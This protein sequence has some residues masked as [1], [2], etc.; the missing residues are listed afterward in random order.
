MVLG[1][2]LKE[3][4]QFSTMINEVKTFE[5]YRVL[6]VHFTSRKFD[7]LKSKTIHRIDYAKELENRNDRLL[8]KNLS[9]LCD[10]PKE[11]ASILVSNFAYGNMYPLENLEKTNENYKTWLKVKNSLGYTFQSDLL[12]LDKNYLDD[13]FEKFLRKKIS[14][15]TICLINH[16]E[17]FTITNN[18]SPIWDGEGLR[19]E[20][21]IGFIRFKETKVPEYYQFFKKALNEIS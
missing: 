20:K 12:N 19:I 15:E 9:K 16:F 13:S 10:S 7:V 2:C 21:A 4:L 14:F 8:F 18:L 1:E 17:K 5:L 3:R 6:K 11:M